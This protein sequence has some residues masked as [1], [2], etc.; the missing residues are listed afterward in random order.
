MKEKKVISLEDKMWIRLLSEN[1][2]R[3]VYT[4]MI[5]VI[6]LPA[7]FL[8]YMLFPVSEGVRLIFQGAFISFEIVSIAFLILSSKAMM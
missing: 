1:I 3:V 8:V 5:L 4:S 6:G 7:L 2:R